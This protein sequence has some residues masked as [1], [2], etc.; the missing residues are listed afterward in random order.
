MEWPL[1]HLIVQERQ[2]KRERE[3]E[4]KLKKKISD[5]SEFLLST[6]KVKY[7]LLN[8]PVL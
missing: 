1:L 3:K 7:F 2:R 6:L 8:E 4:A 5:L